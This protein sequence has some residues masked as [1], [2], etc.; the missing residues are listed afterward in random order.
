MVVF[1][2][3]GVL[4]VDLLDAYCVE[5]AEFLE[6]AGPGAVFPGFEVADGRH[7]YAC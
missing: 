1:L 7:R 5:I 2:E 6:V 3:D 4:V